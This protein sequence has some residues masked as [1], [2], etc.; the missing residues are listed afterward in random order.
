MYELPD[1]LVLARQM[2]DELVG[3]TIRTAQFHEKGYFNLPKGDF[4]AALIGR[5]IDSVAG[6]GKWLF[7][8][9][10]ADM[11]LQIGEHTGHVLY[12]KGEDTVPDKFTLRVDFTDG[13]ALTIRNYG[14]SFIRVV[15]E[16][17]LGR[18]KYPGRLGISPV[19]EAFTFEAFSNVLDENGNRALKAILLDQHKIAG[20][21]NGYFQEIAFRAR[22]HPKG[23]AKELSEEKGKALYEAIRDTLGEA[24][25]LGGK[26]D[27]LDLYGRRGGYQKV[28]GAHALGQP[29]PE[30]GTPIVRL[31]LLGSNTYMCPNCQEHAS[32]GKA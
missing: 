25:R 8:K 18:F 3:K 20:I 4:E 32:A 15:H 22:I 10:G 31:S 11:Y 1:I 7:V 14:M 9:L 29:C 21:S 24:I 13:T 6:R 27:T 28:L 16:G 12:H 30:C 19:D 17:E 2:N 23:K 26:D 5:T